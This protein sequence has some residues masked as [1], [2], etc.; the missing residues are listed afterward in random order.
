MEYD[1]SSVVFL[2]PFWD[3]LRNSYGTFLSSPCFPILWG[4]GTYSV[5]CLVYFVFDLAGPRWPW[6]HSHKIDSRREIPWEEVKKVLYYSLKNNVIFVLPTSVIQIWT[7]PVIDLPE[8]A[9]SLIEMAWHM[10]LCLFIYDTEYYF[11]HIAH[12]KIRFLYRTIHALHHEIRP[13]FAFATQ[14]MHPIEVFFTAFFTVS[15]PLLLGVH[16]LTNWI[17]IAYGVFFSVEDHSGYEFPFSL[18]RLL[19]GGIYGGARHHTGHHMKP[20]KNFE[21]FFTWWD[22][23][24]GTYQHD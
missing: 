18:G 3:Y 13:P 10:A 19:P 7:T 11:W 8:K 15:T 23:L 21:P 16:P 24:F 17:W 12:H 6:I 2:Q 1:S 22:R 9:P 4:I 5:F 14:Y 20:M